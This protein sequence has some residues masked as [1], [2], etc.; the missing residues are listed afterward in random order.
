MGNVTGSAG[1]EDEPAPRQFLSSKQKQRSIHYAKPEDEDQSDQDRAAKE[2]EMFDK[3]HNNCVDMTEIAWGE[4]RKGNYLPDQF[5]KHIIDQ[6]GK[7]KNGNSL[8]KEG[9]GTPLPRHHLRS[10]SHTS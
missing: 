5:V 8:D 6:F 10:S 2:F 3:D 7:K 9:F 4:S 1:S